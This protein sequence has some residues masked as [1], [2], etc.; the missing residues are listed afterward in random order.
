MSGD[1]SLEQGNMV[2]SGESTFREKGEKVP[3][4]HNVCVYG[5]AER[6]ACHIW[7]HATWEGKQVRLMSYLLIV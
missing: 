3:P 1:I 5:K 2:K 7:L 4:R 6:T